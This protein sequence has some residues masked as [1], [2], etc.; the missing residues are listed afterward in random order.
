MTQY[1]QILTWIFLIFWAL[2]YIDIQSDRLNKDHFSRTVVKIKGS[3]HSSKGVL[4]AFGLAMYSLH[5]IPIQSAPV[6]IAITTIL[7][8]S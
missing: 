6:W 7:I 8:S 5:L 1:L 3:F 2:W 4:R